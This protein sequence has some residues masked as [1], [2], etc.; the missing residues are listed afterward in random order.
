[1]IS[2]TESKGLLLIMPTR[3][4]ACILVT[5]LSLKSLEEDL[6]AYRKC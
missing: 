6:K 2:A 4:D 1:M 3:N 5:T